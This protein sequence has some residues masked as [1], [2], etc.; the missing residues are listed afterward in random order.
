MTTTQPIEV[1]VIELYKITKTP[2]YISQTGV[3]DDGNY[4][5]LYEHNGQ[6]YITKH[7]FYF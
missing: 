2:K 6:K 3:D 7:N 4:S 1:T 5:I